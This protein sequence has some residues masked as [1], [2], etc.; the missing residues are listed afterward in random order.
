MKLYALKFTGTIWVVMGL[1]FLL[2]NITMAQEEEVTEETP[3]EADTKTE[4]DNKPVRSP[5]AAGMLIETQ[6]DLVWAPKTL[7]MVLQHRF[8]NLNNE[9][10]DMLGIYGS[11]NIRLA[12]NYGLFKNAQIGAG[13][14]KV[15]SRIYTDVNWKYKLLTQTTSNSMPIALTYYGNIEIGLG[16]DDQ[17]GT[18]YAFTNRLSYFNQLNVSRKFSTN[19]SLM[20]ALNY[21]HFN[22]IDTATYPEM[23]HDNFSLTFAGRCKIGN[24]SSII[25][26]Y[27]QPLTT[28]GALKWLPEDP[29]NNL[30]QNE[31]GLRNLSLGV[32]FST[33]SHAF[34]VFLTTYRNISYQQNLTYNTNYFTDGA[35][36]IGFN[37]TRNWNF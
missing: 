22:Q 37:M 8:G 34:H 30:S 16:A 3:K 26:E 23:T 1:L 21:A 28:P 12:M 24:T 10:F 31:V 4:K 2:P 19:L 5:W 32:E 36:L 14:T 15:G 27:E 6:T 17:W 20:V 29:S 9:T 18:D 25:L 13:T 35:I 11:S 7:E 33:S